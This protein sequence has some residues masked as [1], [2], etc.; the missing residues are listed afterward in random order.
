MAT[1]SLLHFLLALVIFV[2]VPERSLAQQTR[3]L[4][5][6]VLDFDVRSG[7]TKEEAGALSDAFTSQ[8]VKSGEFTVVDRNRIKEILNEQGFQQ[9]ESCSQVECVV[10]A[11]RILQVE[12]IFVGNIG[13]VGRTY[14]VNLQVVDIQTAQISTSS[15]R[16]H[17][18][19][20]DDLL[21][22]IIPE[23]ADEMSSSM[24]GHDVVTDRPGAGGSG[25]LWYVGGGV[26]LAGGAAA[27]LLSKSDDSGTD[28]G[29]TSDTP[30]P[31]A[32]LPVQ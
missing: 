9:S 29:G 3:K 20:I 6:A 24:V 17:Q 16:Q 12:R 25:W 31:K 14:S 32:P 7:L 28:A 22:D 1:R 19:E 8:L 2:C 21:T 13:K 15:S 10:E 11:G 18:G 30:L 26:L 5:V 23:M 4:N 27:V